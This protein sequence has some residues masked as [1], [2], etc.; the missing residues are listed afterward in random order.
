MQSI[1]RTLIAAALGLALGAAVGCGPRTSVSGRVTYNGQPVANG[2]ITFLPADGQGP[3]AGAKISGGAYKVDRLEPGDK[4]VQIVGVDDVPVQRSTEELAQA[5]A[6]NPRGAPPPKNAA[7]VP[8]NAVGNNAQIAVE[9]G[10][11]VLDFELST[12]AE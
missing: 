9:P 10:A 12:P 7:T 1:H 2:A 11:S 4:I 8:S 3:S 6:A 5:A